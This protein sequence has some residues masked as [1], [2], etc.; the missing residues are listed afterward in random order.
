MDQIHNY[1]DIH[2]GKTAAV[3]CGGT[4][5]PH[6]LDSIP[7]VDYLI[8]VNQHAMILPLDYLVFSDRDVWDIVS[9][10]KHCKF[11]THLNKYNLPNVIHAGIWPPMGYSGQRAIYAADYL[12]FKSIHICGMDQ[13]DQAGNREYWWEGPQCKE[14]QRHSHC[15][16]DLRRVKEFIDTLQ[17]PERIFFAS[18]RL[19]E[20]HQ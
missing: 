8:G 19:K 3:L 9:Q 13:Y 1:K 10:K 14:M 5:L 12:G 17:H 18:G 11:I 4:S 20:I 16:S 6:D 7:D 15:K 2:R